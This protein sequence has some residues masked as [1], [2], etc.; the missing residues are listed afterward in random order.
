VSATRAP[1]STSRRT[2]LPLFLVKRRDYC[3]ANMPKGLPPR[4]DRTISGSGS[5][6]ARCSRAAHFAKLFP[7]LNGRRTL[8]IG[9]G[10]G[11]VPQIRQHS[12]KRPT[13][14]GD[15]KVIDDG[16]LYRLVTQ[17]IQLRSQIHEYVADIILHAHP[18]TR[19]KDHVATMV[20]S[21]RGPA[22]VNNVALPRD[23]LWKT[24]QTPARCSHPS[25]RVP[26][27]GTRCRTGPAGQSR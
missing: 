5:V 13:L 3:P 17:G 12:R 20:T 26:P 14:I 15:A 21:A 10:Q 24:F 25:R 22:K 18:M 7:Q 6:S 1:I 4:H 23:K 11:Q 2:L 27:G 8:L 19:R 9:C 16:K